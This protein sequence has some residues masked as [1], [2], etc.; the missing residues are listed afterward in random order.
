MMKKLIFGVLSAILTYLIGIGWL[1]LTTEVDFVAALLSF[2][3]IFVIFDVVKIF[4]AA[5]LSGEIKK[6][7]RI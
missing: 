1:S 5:V 6:R 4:A 3:Y 2:S 7:L